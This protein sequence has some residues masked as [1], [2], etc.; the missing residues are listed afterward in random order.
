MSSG[1]RYLVQRM[2]PEAWT[3]GRTGLRGAARSHHA[4]SRL[5]GCYHLYIRCGLVSAAT[6]CWV[7]HFPAGWRLPCM[8]VECRPLRPEQRPRLA[9]SLK[10]GFVGMGASEQSPLVAVALEQRFG[11]LAQSA[12]VPQRAGWPRALP[13]A[14]QLLARVL[15]RPAWPAGAGRPR[16]TSSSICW[17]AD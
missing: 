5:G 14:P 10:T 12:L 16:A 13:P 6:R 17:R 9:A 2:D 11:R 7:S 15:I 8:W 4:G 1:V 3:A